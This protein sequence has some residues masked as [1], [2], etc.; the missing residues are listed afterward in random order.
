M[1]IILQ[2]FFKIRLFRTIHLNYQSSD[3][4]CSLTEVI[5]SKTIHKT[6]DVCK[7]CGAEGITD[8]D[9]ILFMSFL[10]KFFIAIEFTKAKRW[11]Q[12]L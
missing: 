8:V 3:H 5:A 10:Y 11:K 2:Q 9:Q 4:Y 12:R 7:I 1:Y 6:G